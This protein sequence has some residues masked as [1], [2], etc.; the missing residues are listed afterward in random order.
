[1]PRPKP[2]R[3]LPG[4]LALIDS[5]RRKASAGRASSTLR[6]GIGDDCA[7]L[8]PTTRYE[9]CVTTDFSLENVHFRRD[10]HPPRFS[11]RATI[12]QMRWLIEMP[13][14]RR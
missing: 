7:I 11:R 4:E 8:R 6:L 13:A 5:I 9:I 3:N 1:M 12:P 14:V 10:L 2:T